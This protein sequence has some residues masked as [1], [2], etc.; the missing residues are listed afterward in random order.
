MAGM[1]WPIGLLWSGE[2]RG[3]K[4]WY[5]GHSRPAFLCVRWRQLMQFSTAGV[6]DSN[7]VATEFE[8]NGLF[9][10]ATVANLWTIDGVHI[11]TKI[12]PESFAHDVVSFKRRG[13]RP[14]ASANCFVLLVDP[15]CF[16]RE[17]V[18]VAGRMSFSFK[19]KSKEFHAGKSALL[20]RGRQ[21]QC[22]CFFLRAPSPGRCGSER[23]A[24]ITAILSSCSELFDRPRPM[25]R[26]TRFLSW[27]FSVEA[28]LD[29]FEV[30]QQNM[31]WAGRPPPA[32]LGACSEHEYF[33]CNTAGQAAKT[34]IKC[35]GKMSAP[36]ARQLKY[37]WRG[38]PTEL[39][40]GVPPLQP[41]LH[42]RASKE[43]ILSYGTNTPTRPPQKKIA[44]MSLS[45]CWLRRLHGAGGDG[46]SG[47]GGVNERNFLPTRFFFP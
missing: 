16:G 5:N 43:W 39:W 40:A 25:S 11:P 36:P 24:T 29:F 22:E 37:S 42:P 33:V 12:S 4:K 17:P 47:D 21:R 23:P 20:A 26:G 7:S 27:C 1:T 34:R 13:F 32:P 2:Y 44:L 41:A 19:A 28:R 14:S 8:T 18:V 6:W 10:S 9:F 38:R 35:T 30:L 46:D 31:A 15:R 3:A 45:W